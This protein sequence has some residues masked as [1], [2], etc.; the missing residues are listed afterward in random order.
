MNTKYFLHNFAYSN[1]FSA[2]YQLKLTILIFWTKFARKG[3]HITMELC[4]F[5]LV[6]N[7]GH[8]ILEI[9]S[10]LLQ[11]RLTTSKTQRDMQ[12]SKLS[13]YVA[14]QIDE[15]L[16]TQDPKKYAN[17]KKMSN[18]GGDIAQRPVPQKLNFGNNSQNTRKSRYK[19]FLILSSF[20]EFLCFVPNILSRTVGTKFQ[21][22]LIILSFWTKFSPKKLFPVKNRTSNPRTT[23]FYFLCSKS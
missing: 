21:L 10:A 8:N 19:T 1:Q 7:L 9:Y 2:K 12:Y 18:L 16:K 20:T 5:K 4:I 13:V 23:N 22:K 6:Y 17:I 11:I 15:R 3:V 14:S